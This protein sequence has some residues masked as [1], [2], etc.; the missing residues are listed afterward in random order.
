[1]NKYSM[2]DA[3]ASLIKALESFPE[4][5]TLTPVQDKAP[6]IKNWQ[7]GIDRS[8][9]IKELE[10]G[11]ANGI[12]LITGELSGCILA[13]DCDGHSAHQL[14]EK[15]GGLPHTVSFTSG[16][17]GRAQH[18]YL[19]PSEY[20]ELLKNFTR[21]VLET[22][23]KG[24]Q[25]EI[26]YNASQSVLPPSQHP[27][28]DGYKS[29]NSIENTPIA[30]V[31]TWVIEKILDEKPEQPKLDFTQAQNFDPIPLIKCLS[32]EHREWVAN[33]INHGGRNDAGA[34]LA[35]DLIGT[36]SQLQYLGIPYNDSAR[37][38]F[39]DYCD[40]CNPP[41]NNGER[42]TIWRSAQKDNPTP[43]LDD[44]K[45]ENCYKAWQRKQRQPSTNISKTNYQT[46]GN[47]ALKPE[48]QSNVV[49]FQRQQPQSNI[50][51]IEEKFKQL[52]E[53]NLSKSKLRLDLNNI[54]RE[55]NVNPKEIQNAYREY[56]EEIEDKESQ[57]DTKSD[58]EKIFENKNRQLDLSEYLSGNL[59]KITELSKR[60]GLRPE[61]AVSVFLSA[62]S[63]LQNVRSDIDL[64]DYTDFRQPLIVFNAIVA[65]PSQKKS[66]LIKKIVSEPLKVYQREL[67]EKY[68]Q[69]MLEYESLPEE[70]KPKDKPI[71][72][73]LSI[74][75]GTRAGLR[76]MLDKHAKHGWGVLIIA[77]ELAGNIKNKST[78][79]NIGLEEDEL[80]Y[81]EGNGKREALK[82][83]MAST[84]EDVLL[85]IV[86]GIQPKVFSQFNDG[87]D[88]NG[89]W[90]RYNL[91]SQPL[92]PMIIPENPGARIDLTPLMAGFYKAIATLP[93]L[94]LR[95]SPE[96]EEAMRRLYN[97]CEMRRVE[98]KTQSM[99]ALWGKAPGKIG[100]I[101][102]L[103]HIIHQVES[104][105][106]VEDVVVSKTT[107][108]LAAKLVRFYIGEAENLYGECSQDELA[109]KLV[110]IIELAEKRQ[111]AI[112][113]REIKQFD[114]SFSKTQNDEIRSMFTQL[115]ELG[116]GQL[117]GS[118]SRLKFK[119]VDNCRQ[120]VDKTVDS[121]TTTT[122]G[123]QPTVDTVDKKNKK[124]Q[125]EPINQLDEITHIDD[126]VQNPKEPEKLS[127]VSTVPH[128]PDTVDD[129]ASTEMSTERL[130]LSTV[131]LDYG[132]RSTLEPIS[133]SEPLDFDHIKEGDILFDGEGQPHKITGRSR[134][135]WQTHRKTYISR[136][137]IL[138]GKFHRATVED[139]TK[140]IERTIKG[141]N[142]I[143]A[144]WLCDVYGGEPD[145][146]MAKAIDT[147]PEELAL[148]FDFDCWE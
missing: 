68:K 48:T 121:E 92:A 95:L 58:I 123:L 111:T 67:K 98:A 118:G 40:R 21:K 78:T 53:Q 23:T 54:A 12:G 147:N 76:D 17:T 109:P 97:T 6:K 62:V 52:S 71:L 137:D 10:A 115:V 145:S 134:Q 27:E 99:Q 57:A 88:F 69:E 91:I 84:E 81:Y 130:Q 146:L 35:R 80:S 56:C 18:L 141:K 73:Q 49:P 22:G 132:E 126:V 148:I 8:I 60:F 19:V 7:K 106:T 32:R 43:C 14:A 30:E 105:G 86:G 139:V 133:P 59:S 34:E 82:D 138:Q 65:E 135:L 47:T 77:D 120:T 75:G 129:T 38:L 112:G 116:Y 64:L 63:G 3:T 9:I 24:E 100:R 44:D 13:I 61:L 87:S 136:N 50:E 36:E 39:D 72:R 143:Q 2:N 4:Q 113:A 16:K 90:A 114:R 89:R 131:P 66:P 15:L 20:R 37:G 119:T 46:S 94:H 110:R 41:I 104:R 85:S 101:A 117:E 45:L 83:D 96:A 122:Q 93:E 1:M 25:L 11:R 51:D 108:N 128:N 102:G 144:Q 33:G 26:R 70:D 127:T 5:W 31:P 74:S 79:Y 29:I 124:F 42:E 140:L 125:N 103:L 28:T 142:K 107:L 55:C